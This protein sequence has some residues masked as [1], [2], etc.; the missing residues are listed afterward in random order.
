M[1]EKAVGARAP[2]KVPERREEERK[3]QNTPSHLLHFDVFNNV[4][5]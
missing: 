4:G 1:D 5:G 3:K 2:R